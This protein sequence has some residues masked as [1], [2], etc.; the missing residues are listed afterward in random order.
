MSF[1][2]QQHAVRGVI[3]YHN[4]PNVF[5]FLA[6]NYTHASIS[7]AST[8]A[9]LL[10]AAIPGLEHNHDVAERA[11]L[12][13]LA[14]TWKIAAFAASNHLKARISAAAEGAGAE[15]GDAG[16]SKVGTVDGE[17]SGGACLDVEPDG[18]FT[19]VEMLNE[20]LR[21]YAGSGDAPT[22]TQLV[23]MLAPLLPRTHQLP[24]DVRERTVL[25][26]QDALAANGF[27]PEEITTILSEHIEPLHLK[28]L[29]T[30]Q[31]ESIMCSYHEQ[32]IAHRMF[33]EAAYLRRLTFPAYPSVY[34]DYNTDN[35]IYLGCSECGKPVEGGMEKLRCE[36]CKTK[37]AFCA[38]C[39]EAD[40][41]FG[42]GKLMT[43]CLRCNHSMH[44][45][46]SG[47]WFGTEKGEG[48]AIEGCLCDCGE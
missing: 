6:E 40:S 10:R 20:L 31:L 46:C 4:D 24:S 9:D 22:A 3:P 44:V 19:L 14:Q 16:E 23:I 36:S 48:C 45:G 26:H 37:M 13:R 25:V 32:L 15:T 11:G 18:P 2:P 1:S 8:D 29:D 38:Y 21:Y 39:W 47:V 34:E 7:G 12:Y 28:G 41:P 17:R 33:A 42:G 30:L 35:H 27:L 43:A 5:R